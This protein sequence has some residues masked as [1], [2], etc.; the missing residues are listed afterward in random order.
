MDIDEYTNGVVDEIL[1]WLFK[2]VTEAW[3][4]N[5]PAKINRDDFIRH[6]NKAIQSRKTLIINKLIYE[7]GDLTSEHYEAE[8][9]NIYVQQLKLINKAERDIKMRFMNAWQA[10]MPGRF[11]LKKVI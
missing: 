7:I 8:Q 3:R 4:N 6:K 11:Y 2:L 5:V 1:G 9:S 10:F